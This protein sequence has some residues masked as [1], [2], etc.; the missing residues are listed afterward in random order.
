[1]EDGF[2]N[3]DNGLFLYPFISDTFGSDL[4]HAELQRRAPP[5]R[6]T[7]SRCC[8]RRRGRIRA[9]LRHRPDLPRERGCAPVVPTVAA[10]PRQC[11]TRISARHP[12]PRRSTDRPPPDA[13]S[14]R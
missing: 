1:M 14:A 9:G 6:S 7:R 3:S 12:G 13:T 4:A 10:P 11:S 5:D 2:L 8:R